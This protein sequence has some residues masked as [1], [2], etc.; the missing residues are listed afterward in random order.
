MREENREILFESTRIGHFVRVTAIDAATGIEAIVQGPAS[1]RP[2]E[3]QRLAANKLRY[4]ME[5]KKG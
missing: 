4:V 5:K 3:L 2:D 1:A